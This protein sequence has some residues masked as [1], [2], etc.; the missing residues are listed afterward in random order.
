MPRR[1]PVLIVGGGPVGL[2]LAGELG[3]RGIACELVEQTDGAIVAPKMNEVNARSMEICRRWGI[4]DR[5]FNCPFPADFP[6]DVAFVTSL[7]GHE[8]SRLPRPGR[9]S[10]QPVPESP[11]RMQA[12]SQIWFD[13]IL[14][15]FAASFPGVRLRYR[16]RLDAFT[17]SATGVTAQL[18]DLAG[19]QTEQ[20]E[21]DYLVGCD[22]AGSLVRR[23][24]GIEIMGEGTIGH[25]IN[26][27]FRAPNL[28]ERCGKKPA[29]FFLGID[30]TGLWGSLRIIDP[31]NGLWRL[32][33]DSTDGNATPETVDREFYLRRALGGSFAVEW[34][35]VNIWRR[36]S[37]LAQRYGRDRVHLAGDAVHQLSPTGGMGMN[38]GV[39]DAADIGWKL[40]AV[41]DGWGGAG[42]LE[43][44][45][46]ERRPVGARAV[47]MATW[48][49]K[50]AENFPKSS[51]ALGEDSADGA[52]LRSTIGQE[53]LRA[54]GPEFRTVGLQL[55]YRYEGSPICVPDGTPEPPDDPAEVTPSARPGSRAPH[56][57]LRDGRSILDLYGRGFV[58]LRFGGAPD[59]LAIEQAARQ[60]RVPLQCV[61][62]DEPAAA[63]LYERKLVLVRPDGHVAW[64]ADAPPVDALAMIDRVRGAG[65]ESA[66]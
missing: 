45:D 12:C 39:A 2:A 48:F 13:P 6:L 9:N 55:G 53:L 47:R 43:S 15:D 42:L 30:Q 38:T 11:H 19:G 36:R 23:A 29:T 46:R 21:A 5:V 10:Q 14:K 58:L 17:Q 57:T 20:I 31:V 49:Y 41:L 51:A 60:R 64:R 22:G 66:R 1:V 28:I 18:S 61:G 34:V 44:Y 16:C 54:I 4:A 50:N 62:L 27:F 7:S 40:A 52:R 37:A 35:D 3:W 33:I 8:L 56:V 25:P 59:G 63:A 24:L 65:H 26:L 32:M